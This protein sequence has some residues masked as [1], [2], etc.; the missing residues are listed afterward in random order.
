MNLFE[1]IF[2]EKKSSSQQAG[3]RLKIMLAR[4]RVGSRLPY[5]EDMKQELIDVI[6]K[7]AEVEQ[8][9]IKTEQ[10]QGMDMLEVEIILGRSKSV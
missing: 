6:R 9:D 8:I 10:N 7:Y 4:E 2:G 5:I 3:D 1:K